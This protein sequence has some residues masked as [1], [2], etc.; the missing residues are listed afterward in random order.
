MSEKSDVLKFEMQAANLCNLII[1]FCVH[2]LWQKYCPDLA[3][4]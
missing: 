2:G 1:F 4:I 3:D